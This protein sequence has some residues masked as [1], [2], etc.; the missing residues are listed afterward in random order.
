[1]G[2]AQFPPLAKGGL[3]AHEGALGHRG[4]FAD[5]GNAVGRGV[6][7]GDLRHAD[8]V[9][10]AAVPAAWSLGHRGWPRPPYR[11]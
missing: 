1:M 11:A 9:A 8:A 4:A 2:A 6:S 3:A 10:G 5:D 7:D